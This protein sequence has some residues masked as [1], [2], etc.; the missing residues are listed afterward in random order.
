[1][2]P[3]TATTTYTEDTYT[4]RQILSIYLFYIYM[5]ADESMLDMQA[6][7]LYVELVND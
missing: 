3:K 7:H 4:H 6:M 2:P 5:D 1:M